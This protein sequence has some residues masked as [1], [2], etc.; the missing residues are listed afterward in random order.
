MAEETATFGIEMVDGVSEPAESAATAL[1]KLQESIKSDTKALAEMQKSLNQLKKAAQ[2]NTDQIGKL[3]K[4]M[5]EVQERIGKTRE[6]FIAQGG[7]FGKNYKGAKDLGGKLDDLAKTAGMLPGPLGGIVG[8]LARVANAKNVAKLAA[9]G[10]AA[11]VLVIGVAAVKSAKALVD[12]GIAAQEARRNELLML[13]ASTRLPTVMGRAFGLARNNAKDLQSAVDQVASS[14]TIGRDEVAKYAA[15]LDKMGVRGKNVAPALRAVSLA[16]SGWGSE[17]AT[18]TAA[19]AAQLALTG[20]SVEKLAQRV[21][22]QIGGVV[23][24]KMKSSEVQARKLAE[25]YNSLFGDVDISG[26]LDARKAFNDLFSQSTN[27]GRALRQMLGQITQPLV[28]SL[29]DLQRLFKVVVQN[30][31]IALLSAEIAWLKFQ[32]ATRDGIAIL[33]EQFPNAVKAI[34]AVTGAFGKLWDAVKGV[35]GSEWKE[36]VTAAA[37]VLA[38]VLAPSIWAASAAAWSFASAVLAATW[39]VLAAIGA[40]YLLIKAFEF[41]YDLWGATDWGEL[42]IKIIDGVMGALTKLKAIF[43]DSLIDIGK[44]GIAGFKS[45]FGIQSPS[46]VMAELGVNV[47]QGLEHGVTKESDS[48][49][50]AIAAAGGDPTA[51]A[52]GDPT[53]AVPAGA[54]RAGGGASVSIATLNVQVGGNAGTED[55]RNIAQAVKREL[56]SILQTVAVQTGASFA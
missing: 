54:A 29:T 21:K 53:A 35:L 38:Y 10:L 19:W 34:E 26:L 44:A 7:Q 43:V 3:E 52:G 27:S 18:Q 6:Q 45:I 9:I 37:A 17:R 11:A 28:D 50:S 40:V 22:N 8:A 15:Q 23:A 4:S 55:A 32:I 48:A 30:I 24:Q 1:A 46:K 14:V 41:L 16:A 2:P 13:E 49:Q 5:K 12:F 20:G 36:I 42:G 47:V 56:E 31:I 39:P 51:A 33:K 25:S